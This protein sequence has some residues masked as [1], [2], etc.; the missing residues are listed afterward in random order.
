[1]YKDKQIL[2]IIPAR[3]GSRGIPRK[4]IKDLAGKPLI[5]YTIEEAKKSGYLD[6]IVVSTDDEEI[7]EVAKRYGGEVPFLR[8]KE[9]AGDET[10]DLPV[11][12][13]ALKWLK[14]NQDYV[15]DLVV[16]LRPTSP[17]RE[18]KHIDEAIELLEGDKSA[19]S[20][21]GVCTPTQNP[22]KM[23]QI[24][25]GYMEPLVGSKKFKEPYNTPRQL[26]P[27]VYWQNGH[28]E[29]IRYETI[30]KKHS[31]TGDKILPYIMDQEYSVDIDS[32][33]SIKLA[34]VILNEKR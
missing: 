10:P 2:A 30:M 8:P 23:W 34:E 24:K 9:L 20:V 25:E 3:G 15:P 4:N 11:F 21:R 22:F 14:E 17:L 16:H 6:R 32:N 27:V 29:V 1:M 33:L 28:I 7:G 31:M 19:D 18:A 12:L 26:L 13:H 5:A